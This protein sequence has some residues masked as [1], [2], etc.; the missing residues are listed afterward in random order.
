MKMV[1]RERESL[2]GVHTGFDSSDLIIINEFVV[3]VEVQKPF[4]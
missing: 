3:T 1:E 2:K 4:L